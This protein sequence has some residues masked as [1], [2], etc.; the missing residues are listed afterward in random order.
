MMDL[1][2]FISSGNSGK[3]ILL[4]LTML[5]SIIS[6]VQTQL[7]SNEIALIQKDLLENQDETTGLFNKSFSSSLKSLKVLR[8]LNTQI[9]NTSKICRDLSYETENEIKLDLLEL[10]SL[11]DCKISFKNL[12]AVK[13]E[14]FEK[15]NFSTLYEALL[16]NIRTKADIKWENVF[17]LLINFQDEH[18]FIRNNKEDKEEPSNLT[19]TV[20]ALKIFIH[21]ANLPKNT[22]E[23][24]GKCLGRIDAIWENFIKEFQV[25]RQVKIYFNKYLI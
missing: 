18:L 25:I 11:L 17:E 6:L 9:K 5:Y 12:D 23:F 14:N 22:P 8:T 15:M 13:E 2:K 24:K 10:N 20:K 7:S 16:V 4:L 19:L 21:I 3:R 1:I